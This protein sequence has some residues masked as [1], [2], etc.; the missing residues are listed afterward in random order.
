MLKIYYQQNCKKTWSLISSESACCIQHISQNIST[1][2][3]L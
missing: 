1:L 2:P 3:C